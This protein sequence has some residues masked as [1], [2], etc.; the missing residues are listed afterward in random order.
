MKRN[1][2]TQNFHL[3][4]FAPSNGPN[5]IRLKAA[6]IE[7]TPKMKFAPNEIRD[8]VAYPI[9]AKKTAKII[10]VAGPTAAIH[11]HSFNVK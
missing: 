1:A 4:T 11:P 8:V 9:A 6:R 10:F 3:S 7:L 5:G 2:Q